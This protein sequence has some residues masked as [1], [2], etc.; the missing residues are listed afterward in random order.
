[1]IRALCL[2]GGLSGAAGLSQYP[3]FSQQYLQRLA[4]QVDE[5]TRQVVEF[6]ETA[7]ADG[8]GREEMLQAMA[9]TPLV[10]SQEALWRR[11]FARH[12]RLSENLMLLREAAPLERLTLPHRMA[13]PATLAAV[14]DDFTP[15]VPL[16]VAG[17]A[18]AGTGF[19]GGWAGFAILAGLVSM[20]FRRAKPAPAAK[21][22]RAPVIKA[23]PPVTRPTLVSE[24]PTN[25][26]RLAG[27]QR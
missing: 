11:T 7:L 8:M 19:L 24:T 26:P 4:G 18:S 3:E 13:D 1:M 10:A 6:D 5:L 20:P 22:R 16:S 27:V 9:E 25:R 17:V 23:D 14:W 15:A 12:A 21:K 2:I